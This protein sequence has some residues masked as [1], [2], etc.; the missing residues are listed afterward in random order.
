MLDRHG[1]ILFPQL[2]QM[3]KIAQN[4]ENSPIAS[5]HDN[6]ILPPFSASL[7]GCF[8]SLQTSPCSHSLNVT[9][10]ISFM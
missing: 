9:T 7:R 1:L 4:G 8:G 6:I 5:F 3:T 10:G 2:P